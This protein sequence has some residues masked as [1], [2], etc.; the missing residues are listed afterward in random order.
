[1]TGRQRLRRAAGTVRSR[2]WPSRDPAARLVSSAR[3]TA[4]ALGTGPA[5]AA[6]LAD[7]TADTC[8]EAGLVAGP[9]DPAGGSDG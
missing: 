9:A 3:G 2:V 8:R 1:M 5:V 6:W 4:L 7:G